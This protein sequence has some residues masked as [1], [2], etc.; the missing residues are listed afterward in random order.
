MIGRKLRPPA[1]LVALALSIA[2]EAALAADAVRPEAPP[3]PLR[4]WLTGDGASGDWFG[5]RRRLSDRGLGPFARWTGE[6]FGNLDGGLKTG[7]YLGEL[8]VFGAAIDLQKAVAWP[9]TSVH[10]SALWIQD[11][12]DPSADLVGN[13]DQVSN[14]AGE[15]AVR[16][17]QLYLEQEF[18]DG[19]LSYKLGQLTLDGDFMVSES[20]S[21][22]L[23]AS[24]G[25]L[26]V[27][28][29]NTDAP[30][31]PLAALGGWARWIPRQEITLQVGIY[32]GSAGTEDSNHGF[33]YGI[34]SSEGVAAFA[35]V[36]IA[37]APLGRDATY[38][39]GGYYHS[40]DFTDFGSAST[41]SGNYAL[42]IIADQ[43]LLGTRSDKRL[44]AFF[45]AGISPMADRSEVDWYLDAGLVAPGFRDIDRIGLGF[46]HSHFG[47]DFVSAQKRA[48]SPVTHSE[49]VIEL[50]YRAQLTPWFTLEPDFQYVLDPQDADASDAFVA[51]LRAQI[52]F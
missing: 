48:G 46:S 11:D 2:G 34:G 7:T 37:A 19:S 4:G 33:G 3:E 31:Y 45:R 27:E 47:G 5:A 1:W 20:A 9:G 42:Y 17:Y 50:T 23:N 28:S 22:F 15:S 6:V 36:G 40:G 13:F 51:G 8:L 30:I 21:L 38:K 41:V 29:A 12:N 52:A 32:N 43:V 35:E 16:F 44:A 10:A 24:F 26:P 25:A 39:L 49:S 18:R 14:I